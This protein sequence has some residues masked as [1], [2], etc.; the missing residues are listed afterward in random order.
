M[1]IK[2]TSRIVR[3]IY[4][5]LGEAVG[6]DSRSQYGITWTFDAEVVSGQFANGDYW[7]VAPVNVISI[8][9][10][11]TTGTETFN[12]SMI[13][14]GNYTGFQGY[15][16]EMNQGD[17]YSSALNVA[18]DVD[19]GNPLTLVAGSSL[20][21]TI[22]QPFT[23]T[24][25]GKDREP[26]LKTAAVLTVLASAP[27]S[28]SFR[29][30]YAGTDKTIKYNVSDLDYTI[31]PDLSAASVTNVPSLSVLEGH[32]QRVQLCMH[33]DWPGYYSQPVDNLWWYG[34]DMAQDINDCALSL[35]LDYTDAQKE[36]ILINMCQ[37]G[38]DN[39]QL[40]RED[41]PWMDNG[42]IN[43]GRKIQGVIAS[44]ALG[45]TTMGDYIKNNPLSYQ[46]DRQVWKIVT[47]DSGRTLDAGNTE[48]TDDDVG[49]PEWGIRHPRTPNEDNADL[50]ADYRS[51]NIKAATGS[52]LAAKL[53]TGGEVAWGYTPS[54]DYFE[55]TMRI[56]EGGYTGW[57]YNNPNDFAL[58]MWSNHNVNRELYTGNN[59]GSIAT[60]STACALV[61]DA[62]ALTSDW[63]Y[64][65]HMTSLTVT[66]TNSDVF[67]WQTQSRTTYC[68]GGGSTDA[69]TTET[70]GTSQ[71]IDVTG[72]LWFRC[73]YTTDN[74]PVAT[75][76]ITE[77]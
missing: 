33:T 2:G 39:Y 43:T 23:G 32:M 26:A 42:G 69:A 74:S 4:H 54:F 52:I 14:P 47:A 11:S 31:F 25:Y 67:I 21:S 76:S 41:G 63:I 44:L 71:V 56:R 51:I 5:P 66:L 60:S 77:T 18:L 59:A 73:H 28:G 1:L 20:V 48:Y 24:E 30:A 49:M 13:N 15:D 8:T 72:K 61:I 17:I 29:P 10:A 46:E 16:S 6:A 70:P 35:C 55:R 50:E 38:I 57:A 22:S 45:D 68:E 64:V 19:A 27:A 36:T 3:S 9:P 75:I 12:G 40:M 37:G 62:S 65:E 34:A 7:V 53:I 58:S